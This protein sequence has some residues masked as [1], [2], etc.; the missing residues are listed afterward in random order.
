VAEHFQTGW[1]ESRAWN[2]EYDDRYP[3]YSKS[4]LLKKDL[5]HTDNPYK[6]AKSQL[7]L[8]YPPLKRGPSS[9]IAKIYFQQ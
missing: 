3:D 5:Y 9:A 1:S 8:N 2:S 6:L 4:A 7:I